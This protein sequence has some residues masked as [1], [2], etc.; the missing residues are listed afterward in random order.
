M[1]NLSDKKKLNALYKN[2][3]ALVNTNSS[4]EYYDEVNV[5]KSYQIRLDVS[6]IYIDHIHPTPSFTTF[7]SDMTSND[8][9]RFGINITATGDFP[10]VKKY[11]TAY[12]DNTQTVINFNR[13]QLIPVGNS[14]DLHGGSFYHLDNSNK[15]L[16]DNLLPYTEA[17]NNGVID[18]VYENTKI[19]Y[20]SDGQTFTEII[21]Q[22]NYHGTPIINHNQ[23]LVTFNSNP[24]WSLNSGISVPINQ[25]IDTNGNPIKIYL[26]F[27]KYVGKKGLRVLNSTDISGELV[28]GGAYSGTSAPEEGMIVEGMTGLGTTDPKYTLDVSNNFNVGGPNFING[29]SK[30]TSANTSYIYDFLFQTSLGSS[31]TYSYLRPETSQILSVGSN[32]NNIMYLNGTTNNVGINV[33]NPLDKLEI[34]DG[35]LRLSKEAAYDVA[36]INGQKI[37]FHRGADDS[38]LSTPDSVIQSYN[39]ASGQGGIG[40]FTTDTTSNERIRILPNG[41]VGINS[42]TPDN[43]LDISGNIRITEGEL[44]LDST[45]SN[46]YAPSNTTGGKLT[47]KSLTSGTYNSDW[48]IDSDDHYLRILG[49]GLTSNTIKIKPDTTNDSALIGINSD[50]VPSEALDISGNI[51]I[52]NGQTGDNQGGKLIFDTTLNENGPNKID[53]NDGKYGF[54]VNTDTLKYVSNQNHKWYYGDSSTVAMTLNQINLDVEGNV[55]AS[56][57]YLDKHTLKSY[58]IDNNKSEYIIK[59]SGATADLYFTG[60]GNNPKIYMQNTT[61][62]TQILLNSAGTSYIMNNLSIGKSS[63]SYKLDVLGDVKSTNIRS[64][65]NAIIGGI[66]SQSGNGTN[67]FS[68]TNSIFDNRLQCSSELLGNKLIVG[69]TSLTNFTQADLLLLPDGASPTVRLNNF[70]KIEF[71]NNYNDGNHSWGDINTNSNTSACADWKIENIKDEGASVDP[72]YGDHLAFSF[73]RFDDTSARSNTVLRLCP[74]TYSGENRNNNADGLGDSDLSYNAVFSGDVYIHGNLVVEETATTNQ[75]IVTTTRYSD[76]FEIAMNQNLT[77]CDGNGIGGIA[78]IRFDKTTGG[79]SKTGAG[80]IDG[81]GDDAGRIFLYDNIKLSI[82]VDNTLGYHVHSSG[83]HRFYTDNDG[84]APHLT[85][86]ID[87]IN[88]VVIGNSTDDLNISSP[89]LLNLYDSNTGGSET[90]IKFENGNTTTPYRIGINSS[91]SNANKFSVVTSDDTDIFTIDTENKKIGINNNDP[92]TSFDTHGKNLDISGGIAV[93]YNDDTHFSYI[94]KLQ[95]GQVRNNNHVGISHIDS[96]TYGI[97][98]AEDGTLHLNGIGNG[99]FFN[100]SDAEKMKLTASDFTI[101]TVSSNN[102]NITHYGTSQHTGNMTIDGNISIDCG[103]HTINMND[104]D[105]I[106][107]DNV[108]INGGQLKVE[109]TLSTFPTIINS[110]GSGDTLIRS[111]SL[112]SNVYIGDQNINGKIF[113]GLDD[114]SPLNTSYRI[115]SETIALTQDS[116]SKSL[117]T[118]GD[119]DIHGN[120]NLNN[121]TSKELNIGS[122]NLTIDVATGDLISKGKHHLGYN[123]SGSSDK[124]IIY[125]N[126]TEKFSVQYSD[127]KTDIAGDLHIDSTLKVGGD[128]AN[129]NFKVLNTGETTIYNKLIINPGS[130]SDVALDI[131][132]GD[133]V[134]ENRSIIIKE[135]D[136]QVSFKIDDNGVINPATWNGT[137]ITSNYGGLGADATPSDNGLILV[138]QDDG[139]YL[140]K[141]ISNGD[142]ISITANASGITITNSDKGSTAIATLNLSTNVER[143]LMSPDDKRALEIIREFMFANNSISSTSDD[144][145]LHEGLVR[146]VTNYRTSTYY[147]FTSGTI[148]KLYVGS[149]LYDID[150]PSAEY[151][152]YGMANVSF[153]LDSSIGGDYTIPSTTGEL[154]S[155]FSQTTTSSQYRVLFWQDYT[156]TSANSSIDIEFTCPYHEVDFSIS[157]YK[158]NTIMYV[159][160]IKFNPLIDTREYNDI[161]SGSNGKVIAEGRS[162]VRDGKG[163]RGQMFPLSGHYDF[164]NNLSVRIL[165]LVNTGTTSD[166]SSRLDIDARNAHLKVTELSDSNI[167]Q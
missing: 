143:G 70:G 2:N 8:L 106:K 100:I 52:N 12:L 98:H 50:R 125:N 150:K 21:L 64:T 138:S 60:D 82:P 132:N 136:G 116:S 77:L 72:R 135:S 83:S 155:N 86:R 29:T 88:N 71:T 41:N 14:V 17:M 47:F 149:F 118:E 81:F 16:L 87:K 122:G 102:V 95:I 35:N 96:S 140:P 32:G 76:G 115:E 120:L 151:S 154:S 128:D 1:S 42:I 163:P 110:G 164:N 10:T 93:N 74:S 59:N 130:T 34:R 145:N 139:T 31:A 11:Y 6:N 90:M 156:T 69:N 26:T 104:T 36:D 167:T 68:S 142:G 133:L 43:K 144:N 79:T 45:V 75:V 141:S 56:N 40:I 111:G 165:I 137:I 97:A 123:V 162:E 65:S 114:T 129:P 66:I 39:Y 148:Q 127:G 49:G 53:L 15:N 105:N 85:M 108:K 61:N 92:K 23:G 113:L 62:A 146:K 28:V 27:Y 9:L 33:D 103:N 153:T 13:V 94:G 160:D 37:S 109:D 159:G 126:T 38:E 117:Y 55:T 7:T 101:G 158:Y 107:L 63:N 57:L 89:S 84:T 58:S 5:G 73:K 147:N 54:G 44:I 78:R 166:T 124:F 3:L 157:N 131:S 121:T 4:L 134:V 20:S 152:D 24:S 48:Q 91:A 99:T 80:Y 161:F 18:S 119:V 19:E 67:T 46:P 30:S 112:I 22:T 25:A 51:K